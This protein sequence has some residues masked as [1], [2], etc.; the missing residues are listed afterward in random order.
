MIGAFAYLILHTTRNKWTSQVKR[1]RNPRY[2]IAVLLGIGYF[3]LLSFNMSRNGGGAPN[4]VSSLASGTLSVLLPM[5]LLLMAAYAWVFGTDGTA[6]AFTQAEVSM[7]FTA[8]VSRR[9]LIVYKLVRS[10]AAVLVTSMIWF[11]VFRRTGGIERA[12]SYWVGLSILNTHRLGISLIRASGAAHGITASRKNVPVV[13]VFI[14]GFAVVATAFAGAWGDLLAADGMSAKVAVFTNVASHA[15]VSWILYPFHLAVAPGFAAH[16][17]PWV[18]AMLA[19]LAVLAAHV[20]W[21]LWTDANFE[22]AAAEASAKQAVRLETLR[23]RGVSSTRIARAKRR[24]VPL[25]SS[26][27]P[28]VAIVWKN[29]LYLQRTGMIRTMIGCPLVLAAIAGVFAGR[30]EIAVVMA[31][32]TSFAIAGTVTVFGPMSLRSDL[33]AELAR[34]PILKTMPLSGREIV[35]AEIVGTAAPAAIMQILLVLSGT[36]ALSL[37]PRGAPPVAYVLGGILGGPVLLF[38]LNLANFTIH[39]GMAL[40][41]PAWVKTGEAGTAGV[42]TIGQGVLTVVI[43]SFLLLLLALVPIAVGGGMYLYW[44]PMPTVAIAFSTIAAGVILGL[45]SFGLMHLL[46]RSLERLEPSQVG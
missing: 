7:L 18:L 20:L 4:P 33:R 10:Q 30:S 23:S 38:G 16:G 25:S 27:A 32:S 6:L 28:W 22:E 3:V 44:R 2:A 35:L 31:M 41:F 34:L 37:M 17:Q 39:N 42:E 40:L 15:P 36:L 8:P 24:T 12:L 11:V 19:A 29:F 5:L 14:V 43:T 21:V 1:I 26:G 46:G 13:A 45:E 9:G